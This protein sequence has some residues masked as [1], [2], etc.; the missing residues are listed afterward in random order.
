[1]R[2]TRRGLLIGG[3]AGGGLLVAWAL[4]P[5][6]DASSLFDLETPERVALVAGAE[7]PGLSTATMSHCHRQVRI[8][9][10]HGVDSLNLGHA[11]AVAMASV[12]LP[13]R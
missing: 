10:H 13:P 1:M 8:P 7:G 11:L 9:M 5:R 12:S 2:F 3:A 6:R 4:T